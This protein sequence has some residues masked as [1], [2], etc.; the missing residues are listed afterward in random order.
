MTDRSDSNATPNATPNAMG[1]KNPATAIITAISDLVSEKGQLDP[2]GD[3]ERLDGKTAMVTGSNTG[4]GKAIAIGL[5][6]RGAHV[7]MACR[8]GHPEAGEDVKRQSGSDR[9]EMLKVDLSDLDSASAL[10]DIL[11]DRNITLDIT[12]FNAGLMP[13]KARKGAQGFEVMFMVHFLANRLMVERLTRD[14]VIVPN[15]EHSPRIV[16]VSSESHRSSD[17]IDFDKFGDFIDYGIKDGMGQYGYTKLHLCTFATEL[18]RR[19][20]GVAVHSLCPGPVASDIAREA[21]GWI[22]VIVNPLMRLAFRA[23]DKAVEPVMLLAAS[24]TMAGRTGVYLHMLREKAVSP[25]AADADNG[26]R[27]WEKSGRLIEEWLQEYP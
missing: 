13:I 11:R 12:I 27:L 20:E 9:V 24:Q 10:C 4:L 5:A 2:L 6:R 23:P 15:T 1:H 7:I 26:R 18:A 25:L 22:K 8:S 14:R 21:P 16:F 17:P 3:D 19:L